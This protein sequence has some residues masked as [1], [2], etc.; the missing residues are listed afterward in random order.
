MPKGRG[1]KCLVGAER[2][3]GGLFLEC[4]CQGP[5]QAARAVG[6]REDLRSGWIYL[7]MSFLQGRV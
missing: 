2:H 4:L 5:S 7:R 3:D 6:G 1:K